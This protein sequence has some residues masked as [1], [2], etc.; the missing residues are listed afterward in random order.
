MVAGGSDSPGCLVVLPGFNGIIL[1]A[2]NASTTLGY[3][4]RCSF[5]SC[6]SC[7]LS[8]LDKSIEAAIPRRPECD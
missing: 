6:H 7:A 3:V 5:V 8:Q 2:V 4:G 1:R